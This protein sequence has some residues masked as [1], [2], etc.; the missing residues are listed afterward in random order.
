MD[1]C[2][3]WIKAIRIGERTTYYCDPLKP[4]VPK[5]L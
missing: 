3:L 5:K 2:F 1:M 4:Y